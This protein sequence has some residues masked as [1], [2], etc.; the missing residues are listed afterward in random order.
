[1][2]RALPKADVIAANH[3]SRPSERFSD[4]LDLSCLFKA[5]VVV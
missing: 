5:N 4:G 1:M 3:Q 2:W